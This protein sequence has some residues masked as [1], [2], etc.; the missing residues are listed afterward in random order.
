MVN[1]FWRSDSA[2]V[3]CWIACWLAGWLNSLK[4]F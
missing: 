2:Q 1:R 3:V 4:L